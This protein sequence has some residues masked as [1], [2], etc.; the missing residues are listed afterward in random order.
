MSRATGKVAIIGGG[1]IRTPLVVFGLNEAA[2]VLGVREV[3]LYDPD[4]ERARTMVALGQAVIQRE[5]SRDVGPSESMLTLR[6]G[7]SFEDAVSGTDFVLNSV[8]VGGIAARSAD[9][10]IA[11]Q[12]GYPG[13]ET[14]GPG[15]MAM[16]LRTVPIA[17][18]QAQQVHKFAPQAWLINFTN[19]AGLITQ[20]ITQH[21]DA[22]VV[23]ICDTPT[24]MLHRIAKALA[25]VPDDVHC[26]YLGLNHLGWVRK[27]E[28]RGED[29]TDHLFADD[30]LL[31]QLYSAP[32]FD[33]ALIRS[34]RLIPTEYL[35]FYYSRGRALANQLAHGSTR[36]AEV[37]KLN[38]ALFHQLGSLLAA[39]NNQGALAAY[40]HYLNVRSG[41]YMAL[42]ASGSASSTL[43]PA[44]QEDPFRA[45]TGYHRIAL[46]VM[47]ALRGKS[48]QRVIVNTRNQG[49]IECIAATDIVE[50]PCSISNDVIKPEPCGALPPEVRGLVLAVKEYERATIEAAMTGSELMARKAML[51]YPAIG[52]WE[53][54]EG[55]LRDLTF[56]SIRPGP[57]LTP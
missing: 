37:E 6:E 39:G 29:V 40:I 35:F 48:P 4:R 11:I 46:D 54:S 17:V 28:L 41:S 23:G 56:K 52:E 3:V 43:A 18:D 8:R 15:G 24:E 32:L 1:G 20:A 25:A 21:T 22:R 7:D 12:H 13:Q 57:S 26:E 51:L 5:T 33:H 47:K 10:R 16:A 34:L 30:Y 27:V 31:S 49:A 38:A 14:T 55:L 50:V 19:P 53:P 9:E 36:G 42:E 45:A 44:H 2:A